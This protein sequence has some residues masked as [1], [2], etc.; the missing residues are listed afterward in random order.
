M[1]DYRLDDE[2]E[3]LRKTVREFA[4]RGDRPA[5]RRSSTSATSSPPTSC[6]RW[7]SSG[8][9]GCPSRRSTAARAATTS[10]LCVAL[11]ELARVDSSMAI[12]LEAGVSLGAMPIYRFGT[13]EQKQRVA[14]AAVRR[15]GAGRVR[16]DRARRRLGRRRH[17]DHRP[18]RGRRTGS[19]TARRR[20]SPTPAP[21]SP[22]WSPSPRS[23]ARGRTAARRSRRSSCRRAR[24]G[25]TVGQRYSKVGWNASDTRELSFN[26]AGCPRRTW[27]GSGAAAT[28]SSCRSSTRAG[29]RSPRSRSGWRRAASTSR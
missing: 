6:G 3:A 9:S 11:E 22:S 16:A 18:A 5:D 10:T 24:P 15:R 8:C 1:L 2:T 19:S 28:R 12:T 13:E 25:F 26:D 21:T 20:S 7:A 4:A 14:A 29:S 23:P 27:W 17:A